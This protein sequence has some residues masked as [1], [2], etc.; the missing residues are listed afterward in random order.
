MH[1]HL[2]VTGP[3]VM[4][5][6]WAKG[7]MPHLHIPLG[8]VL[9]LA[10]ILMSIHQDIELEETVMFRDHRTKQRFLLAHDAPRMHQA[11]VQ[12]VQQ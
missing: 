4:P 11:Q 8:E 2:A 1:G 9:M 3:V 6:Q 12:R 7:E 5:G 10:I